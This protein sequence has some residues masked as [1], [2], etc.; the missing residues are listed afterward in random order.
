M[1]FHHFVSRFRSAEAYD[2]LPVPI[3]VPPMIE[4][5][6]RYR[7]HSQYVNL[8]FGVK[9]GTMGD[10]I[11]DAVL[12]EPTDLYRQFLLHPV[13]KPYSLAFQIETEPPEWLCKMEI[14]D[15]EAC[16]ER[17]ESWWKRSRC[18]LLDRQSRHFFV[19]TV[20][21]V[22]NW[23]M[24][25]GGLLGR[26]ARRSRVRRHIS[27]SSKV[28]QLFR[29]LDTQPI[30]TVSDPF[31]HAWETRFSERRAIEGCIGAAFS[32]G[33]KAGEVRK[34]MFDTFGDPD[35]NS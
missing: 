28:D 14:G 24:L 30:P 16:H 34:M 4:G 19:S 21:E 5:A 27:A 1:D 18:L 29:W 3:P 32:L 10:M 23:L 7:G 2:F 8:G 33:F 17:L 11:G 13:V 25:R 22:R 9:G 26:S 31:L 20:S 15:V 12:P 35:H 6:F